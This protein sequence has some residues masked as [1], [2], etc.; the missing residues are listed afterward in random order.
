MKVY[1]RSISFTLQPSC[2]A[3]D[4]EYHIRMFVHVEHFKFYIASKFK[5]APQNWDK[6]VQRC[7]RNTSNKDGYSAREINAFIDKMEDAAIG[8]I[9]KFQDDERA[10]DIEML[11]DLIKADLGFPVRKSPTK[12]LSVLDA[13]NSYLISQGSVK[14]WELS[15]A[16]KYVTLRN[17]LTEFTSGKL[18]YDKINEDFL[19]NY[20]DWLIRVKMRN[21]SA[22][23]E[24][25][26]LKS[27]LRWSAK[28][29]YIDSAN[30]EDFDFVAKDVKNKAI[31]TLTWDEL[32]RVHNINIPATK[33]YLQRAKDFFL[34][35]CFTSMRFSDI[36]S[37][38]KDN[39]HD[40]VID[41]V[42]EKTDT[43][44]QI[45][46][47]RYA[48]EILDRVEGDGEFIFPKISNQ[49]LNAY[50]KELCFLAGIDEPV[51]HI[52]YRGNEKIEVTKPK[53]MLCSTH[54]G[55]RTFISNALAM[56][57]PP[58]TVM[59]WTGHS[60]YK[61]MRPYIKIAGRDRKEAMEKFNDKE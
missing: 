50:I 15:T 25:K 48:K 16:K 23:K 47:N 24:W 21:A 31:V 7:K 13:I 11:K 28:K 40:G 9:R 37:L 19:Q 57:I 59:E 32:M 12:V 53:Y 34:F 61:S 4:E 36:A 27:F 60:D 30:F 14:N 18:T 20:I 56:G 22:K 3:S 43:R 52:Y 33:G 17:H 26:F 6:D 8:A 41:F 58:Y 35:E 44:I 49:K 46:L 5:I 1:R 51:T 42:A 29:G 45:E 54:V 39:I 55:R 38:K 10:L 2:G